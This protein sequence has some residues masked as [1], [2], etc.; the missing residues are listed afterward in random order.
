VLW[1]C[2]PN[3]TYTNDSGSSWSNLTLPS[4][5]IA[6]SSIS[7]PSTTTFY[8]SVFN[9]SLSPIQ[10]GIAYTSDS[11]SSWTFQTM[12]T[13]PNEL[14]AISCSS[15]TTCVVLG[16]KSPSET[17]HQLIF[18]TTNSG[19]NW[20]QGTPPSVDTDG[21]PIQVSCVANTST[22][23][24]FGAIFNQSTNSYSDFV[25]TTTNSGST[26]TYISPSVTNANYSSLSCPAASDCYLVKSSSSNLELTNNNG[27]TW[28]SVSVGNYSPQRVSCWSSSQCTVIANPTGS[29]SLVSLTTIDSG[30]NWYSSDDL[31]QVQGVNLNPF[32]TGFSCRT[33]TMCQLTVRHQLR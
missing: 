10:S 28:S 8:A 33:S 32:P 24:A 1:S 31:P 11:G 14:S 21:Y 9:T 7:C 26:W 6:V 17:Q 27:S 5:L 30:T 3:V 18:Y 22:C 25:E 16:G 12:P 13:V 29:T 2:R 15:I 4:N 20:S 19:T 23:Y